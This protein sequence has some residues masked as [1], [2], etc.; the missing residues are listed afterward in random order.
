MAG[1]TVIVTSGQLSANVA[2][3]SFSEVSTVSRHRSFT[4]IH[5]PM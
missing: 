4:V 3:A 5:S 2:S 1:V